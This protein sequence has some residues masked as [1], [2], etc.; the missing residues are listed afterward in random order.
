MKHAAYCAAAVVVAV[1]ASAHADSSSSSSSA[2]SDGNKGSVSSMSSGP[3]QNCKVVERKTD[4]RSDGSMSSSVTAGPNG[5]SGY[6]SGP[7]GVTVHSGS[8]STSGSTSTA[9]ADGKT[10]VTSSNGDCTI[11]VDPDK[12]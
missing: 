2:S 4:G 7:N 8:G 5:V 10:M 9:T 3:Y 6:T 12:K 1:A 11:Y